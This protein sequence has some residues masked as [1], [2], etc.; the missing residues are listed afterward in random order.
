MTKERIEWLR[1][2]DSTK[3]MIKK[4]LFSLNLAKYDYTVA[5]KYGN[6]EGAKK[7]QK[8]ARDIQRRLQDRK[9]KIELKAIETT[10][11][12]FEKQIEY[13]KKLGVTFSFEKRNGKEY[14]YRQ[15]RGQKHEYVARDWEDLDSKQ[16]HIAQE[17]VWND[18]Y[19]SKDLSPA[20][21]ETFDLLIDHL[22]G[23]EHDQSRIKSMKKRGEW[24]KNKSTFKYYSDPI[25]RK[26]TEKLNLRRDKRIN[27]LPSTPGKDVKEI[28]RI[29]NLPTR[30]IKNILQATRKALI[31]R[32]NVDK[33]LD[34]IAR[35][36]GEGEDMPH[37]IEHFIVYLMKEIGLY[38]E[39]DNHAIRALENY[40]N[41]IILKNPKSMYSPLEPIEVRI[42]AENVVRR[43]RGMGGKF[44]KDIFWF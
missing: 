8:R 31:R 18:R 10:H 5:R 27:T 28:F 34:S 37:N 30:E 3:D 23:Y 20:K 25:L 44:E 29:D 40:V 43:F 39:T 33:K 16:D 38:Q 9:L 19:T 7:A 32:G 42:F 36:M 12:N 24:R 21:N 14:L 22:F 1:A 2:R 26:A 35:N 41:R 11:K 13:D 17:Q 4:L 6:R 15:K